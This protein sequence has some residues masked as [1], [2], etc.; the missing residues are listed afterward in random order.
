MLQFGQLLLR[1]D[2]DAPKYFVVLKPAA[3]AVLVYDM[4]VLADGSVSFAETEDAA[5]WHFMEHSALARFAS[6]PY[7]CS[8]KAGRVVLHPS[9]VA[10]HIV[11]RALLSGVKLTAKECRTIWDIVWPGE[12]LCREKLHLRAS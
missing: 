9:G 3:W 1:S 4:E 5:H 7:N 11:A 2:T 6:V 8:C 12:S 10:E